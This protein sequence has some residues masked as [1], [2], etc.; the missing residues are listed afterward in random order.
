MCIST[1]GGTATLPAIANPPD[2]PELQG[3]QV[4]WRYK[5]TP[6]AGLKARVA[7]CPRGKVVGGSSTI[8]AL[9]YQLVGQRHEIIPHV[10]PVAG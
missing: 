4:D 2:W 8:N 3:S 6:Q 10:A 5:T 1:A 7:T 9:S